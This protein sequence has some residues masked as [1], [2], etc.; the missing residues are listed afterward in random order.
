MSKEHKNTTEYSEH[1]TAGKLLSKS[2]VTLQEALNRSTHG[3]SSCIHELD[4]TV[5][6]ILD[7]QKEVVL[8]VRKIDIEHIQGEVQSMQVSCRSDFENVLI[9]AKMLKMK[10]SAFSAHFTVVIEVNDSFIEEWN[11]AIMEMDHPAK[12]FETLDEL[13][14]P[15]F[16]NLNHYTVARIS[17]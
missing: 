1:Q 16:L 2:Y 13:K 8:R 17:D 12:F 14:R 6:F 15:I 9:L 4:N 5:T 7:N 11:D 3:I 10:I